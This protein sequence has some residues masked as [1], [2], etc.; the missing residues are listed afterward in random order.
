MLRVSPFDETHDN[1][2]RY[3]DKCLCYHICSLVILDSMTLKNYTAAIIGGGP[4]GCQ[5]ALW[6]KMMGMQ[7]III[8]SSDHLGGLQSLSPYENQWIAGLIG[9]SGRDLAAR[10]QSHILA[11]EIDVMLKTEVTTCTQASHGFVIKADD[12]TFAAKFIVLATGSIQQNATKVANQS[13][14]DTAFASQQN[15]VAEGWQANLPKAFQSYRH[16]LL[17]ED[18]FIITNAICETPVQGMFAIGEAANRMHPCVVTSMADGVVA[19]KAIQSL[20]G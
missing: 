10:I 19:A 18:G 14:H 7:P 15:V 8:E 6:L 17:N 4:A 12:Q 9:V 1:I 16:Q 3:K 13:E 2:Y 11:K 5:C 20:V